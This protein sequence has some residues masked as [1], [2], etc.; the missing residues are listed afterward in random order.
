MGISSDGILFYGVALD[1]DNPFSGKDVEDIAGAWNNKHGC[2]KLSYR[3]A[4]KAEWEAWCE[5]KAKW[6][7]TGSGIRIGCHCCDSYPMEYVTL[8]A[9]EHT[10]SQGYPE[11]IDLA[12]LAP[13]QEQKDSLRE[14]CEKHGID[15]SKLGWFLVSWMG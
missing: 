1:E 5:E 2:P 15:C 12:K 7:K 14:F 4:S 9:H 10:A 8:I 3:D 6:E 11:E 13:T